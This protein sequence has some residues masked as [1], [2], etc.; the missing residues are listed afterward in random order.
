MSA[1]FLFLRNIY[2]VLLFL[3]IEGV[4]IFCY[5]NSEGE[6][7]SQIVSY[8]SYLTGGVDAFSSGVGSYFS[9]KGE[10]RELLDRLLELESELSAVKLSQSESYTLDSVLSAKIEREEYSYIPARVISN[11]INRA[12]NY[13]TINIGS[14]EGVA[15]DMALITPSAEMVGYITGCSEH[16]AVAT[17]VLSRKFRSS[18]KLKD[19]NYFGSLSWSGYSRYQL[20]LNEL[21]KYASLQ[22]GDTIVTTGFSQIFPAGITIGTVVDYMLDDMGTSFDVDIELA[23]DLSA[24]DRVVV[25][26]RK[27]PLIEIPNN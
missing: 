2:V 7:Q 4:A 11:S 22:H 9:L 27:S 18:G 19:D 8:A 13:I 14:S 5:V 16:Y 26:G 10:N 21:S 17:S 25:V 3:L 23:A 15:L 1:L 6:S 12:N 20:Q 24:L